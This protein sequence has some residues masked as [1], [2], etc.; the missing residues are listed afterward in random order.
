MCMFN[1]VCV[2]ITSGIFML[3]WL[4]YNCLYVQFLFISPTFPELLQDKP[5]PQGK[6]CR[7]EIEIAP[8]AGSL[9]AGYPSRH[10]INSI[11]TL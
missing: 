7:D 10:L 6:L 5:G 1:V 9:Q 8:A 11:T 3:L 2:V 4:Q